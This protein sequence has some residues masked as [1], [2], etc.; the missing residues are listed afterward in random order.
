M[1]D[2]CAGSGMEEV[3]ACLDLADQL[4]AVSPQKTLQIFQERSDTQQLFFV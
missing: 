1:C 3:L 2:V 4:S